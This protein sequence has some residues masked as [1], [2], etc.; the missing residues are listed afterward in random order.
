[1]DQQ[2]YKDFGEFDL[3]NPKYDC[4]LMEA[5]HQYE[6]EQKLKK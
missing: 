4:Y 1:M 3:Y 5:L 6:Q 2:S